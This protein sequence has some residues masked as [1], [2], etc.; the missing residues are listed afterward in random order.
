MV[1]NIY[2]M[3]PEELIKRLQK[4]PDFSAFSEIILEKI[5]ELDT[6]VGFEDMSISDAG[7]TVRVRSLAVSYLTSILSPIIDFKEPTDPEKLRY[8]MEEKYGLK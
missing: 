8:K 5:K 2:S 7:E 4:N 1:Y 3:F 6:V